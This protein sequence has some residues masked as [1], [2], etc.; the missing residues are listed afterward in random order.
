MNIEPNKD[1]ATVDYDHTHVAGKAEPLR[2]LMDHSSCGKIRET[3]ARDDN[4][5]EP[6]PEFV[7]Y[8]PTEDAFFFNDE[9]E[10]RT[11]HVHVH[12]GVGD[13]MG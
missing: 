10:T 2:Q 11:A 9:N 13:P 3:A 7:L 8:E 12:G 4:A 5:G 1:A 6:T